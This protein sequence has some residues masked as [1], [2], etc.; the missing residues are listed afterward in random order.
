MYPRDVQQGDQPYQSIDTQEEP[1]IS[2]SIQRVKTPSYTPLQ[3]DIPT[4]VV[5]EKDTGGVLIDLTET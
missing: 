3:L 2:K 4:L 5:D 1:F